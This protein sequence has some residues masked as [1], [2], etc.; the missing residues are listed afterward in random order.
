MHET[1]RIRNVLYGI[2]PARINYV[3]YLLCTSRGKMAKKGV[4]IPKDIKEVPLQGLPV[5]STDWE[6]LKAILVQ[7]R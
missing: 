5:S 4:R 6:A 1:E 2:L 7:Q 3:C